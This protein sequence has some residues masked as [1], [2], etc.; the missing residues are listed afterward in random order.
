MKKKTPKTDMSEY[1]TR[2]EFNSIVDEVKS[3]KNLILRDMEERLKAM[4]EKGSKGAEIA[5]LLNSIK[6]EIKSIKKD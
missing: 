5:N 4:D 3:L 6:K 1:L 2:K